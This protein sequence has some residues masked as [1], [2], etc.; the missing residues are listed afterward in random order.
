MKKRFAQSKHEWSETREDKY[1]SDSLSIAYE[2]GFELV[3]RD[4]KVYK[5]EHD[6][7]TIF[8]ESDKPK[9][10]WYETW[11]ELSKLL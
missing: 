6:S 9:S 8:C 2:L 4:T 7:E 3:E 5:L 1:K 11:L 10:L